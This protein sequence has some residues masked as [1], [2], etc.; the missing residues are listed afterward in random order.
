[1]ACVPII[2]KEN[3]TFCLA[4]NTIDKA[5][6]P[7]MYVPEPEC[8]EEIAYDFINNYFNSK[9]PREFKDS[10]IHKKWLQYYEENF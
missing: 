2:D 6:G 8:A 7:L 1:M 9:D 4:C 5:F 3:S 10:E